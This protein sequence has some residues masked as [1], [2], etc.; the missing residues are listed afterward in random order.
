M[1][2][3]AAD[4]TV[5]VSAADRQAMLAIAPE[6]AI[7]V[8]SNGIDLDVYRP[9]AGGTLDAEIDTVQPKFVFT[10]KMDYRPNIDAVL[11]FAEEVLPL[12][13]AQEPNACLPARGHEPAR[14]ARRAARRPGSGD[15]RRR[16]ATP[17]PTSPALPST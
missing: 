6:A 16:A 8:V 1:I 2:L 10:G 12:V 5:A 15:H 17:V 14:P 4:A 11:W 9:P 3:Q 7:T 13:V